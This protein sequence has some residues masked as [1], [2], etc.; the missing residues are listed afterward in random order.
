VLPSEFIHVA[1]ESGL[2]VDIG[3]WVLKEACFQVRRWQE[4]FPSELLLRVAVN[5]SARQVY[6]PDLVHVIAEILAETGLDPQD[7]ELEIRENVIM[8]DVQGIL[9]VLSA[10]KSLG[11][12]LA[13]DD[14]GTGYS[15]LA[16]LKRFPIDTLKVDGLLV[17]D[18]GKSTADDAIMT[19]IIGLA[20]GLGLTVVPERVE[21][22]EQLRRL[23]EMGCD[24]VQGF[25][26]SRPLSIQAME[27][28]LSR[29]LLDGSS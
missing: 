9:A 20:H 25:Y 16:H 11:I 7:L 22:A 14:F 27:T 15:S 26:F 6:E 2:I 28:L 10:L 1:E 18:L 17:A 3:R 13:I 29:K 23:H 8:E 19:A 24:L 5:F 21:T 4:N 12:R